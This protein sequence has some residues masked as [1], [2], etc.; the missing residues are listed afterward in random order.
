[1]K[2]LGR[3]V[4]DRFTK[5]YTDTK[6]WVKNWI[7][8]VEGS[9]WQK[10]ADIKAKYPSASILPKN[11]VIFNVKGNSYRLEAKITYETQIVLVTWAGPHAEYSKRYK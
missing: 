5:T 6:E 1:M 4:L 2:L 3:N 11:V 9:S 7:A 8:D 10:P